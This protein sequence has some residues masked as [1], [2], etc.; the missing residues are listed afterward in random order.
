MYHSAEYY[1]EKKSPAFSFFAAVPFGFTAGELFAWI[2]YGGGQDLWDALA[3]E[4]N[5]KPLLSC[6]TGTQM[7]GWSTREINGPT[8]FKGLRYRMPGMGGE[9]LRRLGAIVVNVPGGEIAASFR[10][11]AIEASEWVG[12]WLDMDLGLHKV[13]SFYYFPGFHEPGTGLTLGINRRVWESLDGS[14][15]RIVQDAAA[16]EYARSVAEFNANNAFALRKLRDEGSAKIL[17]LDEP[18]LKAILKRVKMSS[19]RPAPTMTCPAKSTLAT[20][21]S[22]ARSSIGATSL[23]APFST[24]APSFDCAASYQRAAI[25][26]CS[27]GHISPRHGRCTELLITCVDLAGYSAAAMASMINTGI[28]DRGRRQRDRQVIQ[29]RINQ[30]SVRLLRTARSEISLQS[31]IAARNCW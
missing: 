15:R 27:L 4:F 30:V 22:A 9:V 31:V 6:N 23:N 10:S 26:K 13:A 20:R 8:G 2:E 11:G 1:W 17:K 24:V 14:D 16:A 5:V 3:A 25:Q 7:A 29:N 12:P 18:L 28:A 21:R 19:L